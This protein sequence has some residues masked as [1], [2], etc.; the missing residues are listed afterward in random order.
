M[1]RKM[2]AS[3]AQRL[4]GKFFFAL[5]LCTLFGGAVVPDDW[6]SRVDS[7]SAF[8]GENDDGPILSDGYPGIYL[9]LLGNGYFSNNKGVRSDTNFISGIFNGETTSPS[10]RAEIPAMFDVTIDNSTT[11]GVL[12]D[13]ENAT[14]CRRGLL[15]SNN[16]TKG[17][18]WYELRWYAHRSRRHLYVMELEVG[19]VLSNVTFSLTSNQ[20]MH[21]VDFD[22]DISKR[23]EMHVNGGGTVNLLCGNTTEPETTDGITHRVCVASSAVPLTLTM[24]PEDNGKTLTFISAFCTSLDEDN[25]LSVE[26]RAL[27]ALQE[28]QKASTLE[29]ENSNEGLRATHRQAWQKL[30]KSGVEIRGREDV[31]VA[32]NASLYA[33]LS[34]VRSDWSFGL[35]P[36]GLTN[37]Y[38]GH[39]FWDTETWM[40]PSVLLLHNDIARG[41]LDYRFQRLDGARLKAA[42]YTPP[43]AGTMFPW[44]S[45]FS[46][47]ETCPSWAATGSREDHI[48]GDISLAVWSYYM[49][50]ADLEWLREVGFPILEGVA[51]FWVS[52]AVYS[53]ASEDGVRQQEQPSLAQAHILDIIPPDE[54]VDHVDDSVYSN[55]VAAQA[56]RYAVAAAGLLPDLECAACAVYTELAAALVI[57]IDTQLNIHP[58]YEGYSG[59]NIKQADVVLLHYPLG[60]EMDVELQRADLEYYSAR[61]DPTGPAMTWG[62][63]SIGYLD[64]LDFEN[65]N[66]F[67]NM[68]FQDNLQLPLNV[69]TETV[70]EI[71]YLFSIFIF[72]LLNHHSLIAF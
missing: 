38:N 11:L 21:S 37:Y 42:S 48:S 32:V 68:S 16:N 43:W 28:G 17:D 66:K 40:Y 69:W 2:I 26:A 3:G 18:A 41:L 7:L 30:W 65:A 56:L 45:A 33:I 23:M 46:G 34:S 57:P 4:L 55:F 1:A 64:L 10:H 67:F 22:F 63:H 6:Q 15:Q 29:K 27:A 62:M 50:T 70:R 53:S 51:D 12:M 61:T 25:V 20:N 39:S 24:T 71:L 14:Y 72:S 36:G 54:Y 35:A 13:V 52:R 59:D 58:E 60:L 5:I 47:V 19:D 49:Q 8:Y 44:E 31:G 9:P